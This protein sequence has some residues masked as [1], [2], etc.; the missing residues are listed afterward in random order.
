M[1]MT[2]ILLVDDHPVVRQGIKQIL[3]DAFQAV[4][5]GEAE[6]AKNALIEIGATN[7][8]VVVLD[9]TMPGVSGL[10][11]LREIRRE[12]PRLPVLVLSMHPAEQFAQRTMNAGASGY[13]T[14][15]SGPRELVRA[16]RL[17]IEGGLY[18]HP[19]ADATGPAG[20]ATEPRP[21]SHETLS[22]REYQIL[23][24]LARGK[25]VSQIAREISLS[26]KTVSTYRA[27]LSEK[28]NMHTTAELIRYAILNRLVD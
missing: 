8:D 19:P 28:M 17:L 18:V 21:R 27:R 25:T 15:H 1:Q 26:V 5:V 22:D 4:E 2:R 12:R 11:V 3:T 23:R 20:I 10:G 13:L 9:I 7:W 24:M 16:I 14:K 6:D